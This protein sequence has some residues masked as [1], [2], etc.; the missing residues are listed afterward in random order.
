[1]IATRGHKYDEKVLFQVLQGNAK[2]IGLI[3]SQKKIKALFDRLRSKGIAES[4]LK[5]VH[6]PIGFDINASTFDEIA[7]SIIVEKKQGSYNVKC[8]CLANVS[9]SWHLIRLIQMVP[10]L[11][12]PRDCKLI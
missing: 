2:Y 3:H 7:L 1:M 4:V 5:S 11:Y 9:A 8:Q 6:V 12:I 10:N